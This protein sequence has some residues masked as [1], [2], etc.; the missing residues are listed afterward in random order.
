MFRRP[1][2]VKFSFISDQ[3]QQL[4]QDDRHLTPGDGVVGTEAVVGTPPAY[5]ARPV[6]PVDH[7]AA[8]VQPLPHIGHIAVP[9]LSKTVKLFNLFSDK[10]RY[11]DY[12]K[13]LNPF[14]NYLKSI[15]NGDT[16]LF[17][18]NIL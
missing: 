6:P 7:G 12:T 14:E 3:I 1:A 15:P 5:D 16:C 13:M 18:D 10:K 4:A 8:V 9:S 11:V 17:D 2:A